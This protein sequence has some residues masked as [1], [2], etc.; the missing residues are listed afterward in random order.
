MSQSEK[1]NLPGLTYSKPPSLMKQLEV[2]LEAMKNELVTALPKNIS[3]EKFI[4]TAITGI[5]TSKDPKKLLSCDRRSLYNAVQIAAS[6]GLVLDGREAALVPF[7]DTV[8]FMPMVQGLVKLARNSGQISTI[9]A[10]VVYSKDKFTYRVG[11]DESPIHEPD[12]FA[13]DRGEAVGVWAL[14]TLTDGNKIHAIM[15]RKRVMEIASGS[16]NAGQYNAQTG[17]HFTEWW[18]KT[19]IKNVLKYAPKA[20]ELDKLERLA[21]YDDATDGFDSETGEIIEAKAVT[22]KPKVQTRASAKVK[23][24]SMPNAAAE[25]MRAAVEEGLIDQPMVNV[26]EA[27]FTEDES[28]PYQYEYDSQEI[29]I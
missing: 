3:P 14:I 15:P 9:I 6:Y 28:I 7:G 16:K 1:E 13:D 12:W 5:R 21:N 19:A 4:S 17:K 24:A 23:A 18:K 2:G 29:P 27:E 20:T 11:I 22:E 8:Q 10:E 25:T 26:S